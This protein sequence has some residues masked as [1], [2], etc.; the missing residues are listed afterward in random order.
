MEKKRV[1][2]ERE[3][4]K[5]KG[6]KKSGHRRSGYARAIYIEETR[7]PPAGDKY[8]RSR[9]TKNNSDILTRYA[10]DSFFCFF[11]IFYYQQRLVATSVFIGLTLIV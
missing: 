3:R 4:G 5:K 10:C 8:L 6:Y 1:K 7:R 2:K 9:N 11:F